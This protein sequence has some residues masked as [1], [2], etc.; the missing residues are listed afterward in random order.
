[1]G[2]S[3]GWA[4][5]EWQ[6]TFASQFQDGD[7]N[8]Y[9]VMSCEVGVSFVAAATA[10]GKVQRPAAD[11]EPYVVNLTGA[12]RAQDKLTTWQ[13]GDGDVPQAAQDRIVAVVGPSGRDAL[14]LMGL[15][16]L[17]PEQ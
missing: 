6:D 5:G 1:L 3:E 4:P 15:T 2:W 9:R 16:A 14:A 13:P 7:G 12:R 10:M 17:Q 11:V 8:M